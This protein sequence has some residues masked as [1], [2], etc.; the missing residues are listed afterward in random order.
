MNILNKEKILEQARALIDEGKYD[1][2]IREYEKIVLADPTDLRVKLKIAELHTK[3]KQITEAIR[4][5]RE[6]AD[7]YASQGFYLKAVTVHKNIIRLNPSLIEIN[8]QLAILYENMGL[9][10]DAIRQYD[11][12]ASALDLKGMAERSL[13]VRLRIVKL[14][15]QDGAARVKLAEAYQRSGKI[16]EAIDQYEEYAANLEGEGADHAKLADLFEKVLSHR[17]DRDEM[18]RKLIKIY[19]E[20]G[21]TKKMLKWLESG[22]GIVEHDPELLKRLAR[23]YAAQNQNETAR[24]KYML[25]AELCREN[26]EI[27]RALDAYCDILA[28]LP[29]EEDR[30]DRRIEEIK[31][32][33]MPEVLARARER[34]EEMEREEIRRQAEETQSLDGSQSSDGNVSVPAPHQEKVDDTASPGTLPVNPATIPNRKDADV[35]FDLGIAYRKMGLADESVSELGKARI[36]YAACVEAGSKEA[37]IVRR[38]NRI[39]EMTGKTPAAETVDTPHAQKQGADLPQTKAAVEARTENQKPADKKKKVSFV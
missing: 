29:D 35:A 21:D 11:I 9:A 31:P 30:L 36:I 1:R 12:L 5:Y 14:C 32:G 26:G 6:V 3:R 38:I 19:E 13:D 15:P 25:L 22:K 20:A 16:E 24:T 27:D 7:E 10:A 28:L 33:A 4:I 23:L 18:F 34:R 17:P 37:D 8:E 2:A 39:D